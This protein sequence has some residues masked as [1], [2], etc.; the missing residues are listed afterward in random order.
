MN[1][2]KILVIDFRM[3]LASGIGTYITNL[4]PFLVDH[5]D[6]V[7]LTPPEVIKE[8]YFYG[9]VKIVTVH[10]QIYS[11][12]EQVELYLKIPRCDIFWSPHY[13]I[14]LLPV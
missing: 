1:M 6:V 14:Q 9:K 8:K 12:K 2:K 4:V 13:N 11:I 10:S 7:L 3:H 5:F